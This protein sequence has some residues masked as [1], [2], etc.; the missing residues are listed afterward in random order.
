MAGLRRLYSTASL[1]RL[2]TAVR[3]LLIDTARMFSFANSLME[4]KYLRDSQPTTS[5]QATN[6]PTRN[7][8]RGFDLISG[9]DFN[10]LACVSKRFLHSPP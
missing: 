2:C 8:P 7:G 10:G 1:A 3:V 9:V 5:A 6:T 4:K